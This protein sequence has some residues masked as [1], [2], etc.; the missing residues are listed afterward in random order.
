MIAQVN[1]II[2]EMANLCED[3]TPLDF[4]FWQE[5]FHLHWLHLPSFDP[6]S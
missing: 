3:A 4:A 1:Y 2:Y 5:A 6:L